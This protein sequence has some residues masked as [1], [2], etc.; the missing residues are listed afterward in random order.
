M[1]EKRKVLTQAALLHDIGKVCYRAESTGNHSSAGFEYLKKYLEPGKETD[2]LLS[3]VLNHHA[4]QLKKTTVS[5]D[6]LCYLVYEADNIAAGTDRRTNEGSEHGFNAK[7]CL[8]S[9]FNLL[10][11]DGAGKGSLLLKEFDPEKAI[12]YPSA[13]T[14]V[15]ASTGDYANIIAVLDSNFQRGS[16]S[17]MEPNELL[18]ILEGALTF[19]PSSTAVGEVCDISLYDHQKITAAVACAMQEYFEEEGINDYKAYCF[20]SKNQSFRETEAFLLVSGDISG[21][22]EFIYSIPSAGA[23]KSL[24]GRSFYLELLLEN[25]VDEIL[26]ALSLSRA[27]L[28]YTGGGHFY[29]L[30]ANTAKTKQVI[31]DFQKKLDGWF[32]ER[33]GTRLYL[34]LAY[35]ACSPN[36]LMSE[37]S[38]SES[39]TGS[40]F[41]RLSRKLSKKKLARYD[42]ESLTDLFEHSSPHNKNINGERE[43]G[44]CHI[45]SRKLGSYSARDSELMVCASCN[46]MYEL[47]SKVLSSDLA[48]V[49]SDWESEKAVEVFG[50]LRKLYIYPLGLN[51]TDS[52]AKEHPVTRIYV[53]NEFLTGNA[54]ATHLW[55][56][57]YITRNAQGQAADFAELAAMS[58]GGAGGINRLG[59]LRA[60]VDSLGAVFEAGFYK[61]NLKDHNRYA[62]LSRYAALSRQLSLFFKHYI[63]QLC[64]GKLTGLD[65]GEVLPFRLFDAEKSKN[66]KVDIVYSGGDDVF[67]VGAWDDLLEFAVDLR[68]ALT[69]FTG[70]KLTFSAGLGLFNAAFPV[71][72]MARLTGLLEDNAKSNKGKNSVA[73][74]GI[75]HEIGSSKDEAA[76][77]H[78][79]AWQEFEEKV[80]GEKLAFIE[81]N[82]NFSGRNDG[83]GIVAGKTALYRLMGLLTEEDR[84][85]GRFNL[86]RFAYTVA[87]MEPGPKAPE[88]QKR[89]YGE[90]KDKFYLW[91]KKPQERKQLVTAINLM[92]YKLRETNKGE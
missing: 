38:K 21:I 85:D 46:N 36:E 80:C 68:R 81:K 70:G 14:K 43:C 45:S 30:A 33:Y 5:D 22:Q 89:C 13:A 28:I 50:Y 58:G 64:T 47:G 9:V 26:E 40:V 60:D 11:E 52:F 18:K 27:N 34:A 39:G 61:E 69:K 71:S 6:A 10:G 55:V 48:I 72:Q 41:K 4:A 83:E 37:G 78:T 92:V 59:V 86:A 2:L 42:S 73:L 77:Q 66:R 12:N 74:F 1:E 82:F 20:G 54:L 91:A 63:N 7:A 17:S 62:T 53:K 29:L 87:R 23:L 75:N 16:L 35:E 79:F 51:E 24:R 19:V 57:D 67:M 44:I 49:V 3:C 65:K 90:I 31:E 25:V 56:G 15:D 84:Q 88:Q 76:H 32:L 8:E